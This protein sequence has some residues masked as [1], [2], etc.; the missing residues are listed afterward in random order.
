M[1]IKNINELLEHHIYY[2]QG[3][4]K[5]CICCIC[6]T[7]KDGYFWMKH[8]SLQNNC[9]RYYDPTGFK[10]ISEYPDELPEIFINEKNISN[11]NYIINKNKALTIYD[12]DSKADKVCKNKNE[13]SVNK[14]I[15]HNKNKPK[16][17]IKKK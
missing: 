9:E 10:Y 5:E 7:G 14:F 3:Y 4:N 17:K 13:K 6:T 16:Q 2:G 1:L 12:I 8:S 15:K 11:N